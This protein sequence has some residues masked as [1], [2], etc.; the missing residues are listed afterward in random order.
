MNVSVLRTDGKN[1]ILRCHVE[2]FYPYN[3][4]IPTW[5]DNNKTV[6][7]I[8]PWCQRDQLYDGTYR[9]L[10]DYTCPSEFVYDA[11]CRVE[12]VS[13]NTLITRSLEHTERVGNPFASLD[14]NIF[15]IVITFEMIL[16]TITLMVRRNRQPMRIPR[17]F[18]LCL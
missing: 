9:L 1:V 3:N 2:G 18:R 14:S 10:C 7:G 5:Y 17:I 15:M 6:R 16:C 13:S 12:C 8:R 4:A 11:T